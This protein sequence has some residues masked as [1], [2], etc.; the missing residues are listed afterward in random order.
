MTTKEQVLN[1]LKENGNIFISGQEMAE[2]LFVTRAS[3]WKSIKTL[4]K[5]G[6]NIEA[7]TNRGYRLLRNISA[8]EEERMLKYLHELNPDIKDLEIKLYRYLDSTNDEAKRLANDNPDKAYIIVSDGQT[9]GRGRRGREFYSPEGTGIYISFLLHPENGLED[10]M[11]ITCMMAEAL[12]RAILDVTGLSC[13]IKWVNDIFYHDRKIA[14]VLTEGFTSI[15]DGQLQYLII[16]VGINLYEP[17]DGFPDSIKYS[18]GALLRTENDPE[19]KNK[20]IASLINHFLTCYNYPE[21]N[22][23]LDDYREHSMLIGKYIKINRFTKKVSSDREYAYVTGIDDS[24][25]LCVRYDDDSTEA[26]FTGEVSV[27]R[28]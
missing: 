13:D 16:G 24:G 10:S 9:N 20:L 1:L 6:Y 2:K 15:E 8:P 4:Q 3:V 27:V 5:E 14:G 23:F 25:H 11:L 22:P 26:L 17:I 19:L 28:Y 7:V 12:R 21:E 18:A